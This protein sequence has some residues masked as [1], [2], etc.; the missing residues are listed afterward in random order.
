MP[1]P[2]GCHLAL[3]LVSAGPPPGC[4]PPSRLCHCTPSMPLHSASAANRVTTKAEAALARMQESP[5]PTHFPDGPTA[6]GP[7]DADDLGQQLLA[8]QLVNCCLQVGR[9]PRTQGIDGSPTTPG[10]A[11]TPGDQSSGHGLV[12]SRRPARVLL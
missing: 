7:A 1:P 5:S 10:G 3:M 6:E 12:H 11:T 2:V 8:V 4:R 9:Q